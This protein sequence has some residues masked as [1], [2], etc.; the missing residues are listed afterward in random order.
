VSDAIFLLPMVLV[1][2]YHLITDGYRCDAT[3][4]IA[5]VPFFI[6]PCH[7]SLS[8]PLFII[9]GAIAVLVRI[10]VEFVIFVNFV[11]GIIGAIVVFR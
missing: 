6:T 10:S 8:I 3:G 5:F 1:S 4:K 11:L 2:F 9:T 7:I